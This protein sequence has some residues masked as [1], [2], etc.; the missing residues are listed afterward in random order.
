MTKVSM[1]NHSNFSDGKNTP[2]EMLLRAI[3]EGFTHYTF[4]DH[5]F[6]AFDWQWGA[7]RKEQYPDYMQ[8]V[9]ALKEKYKEQINVFVSMEAEYVPQ[10]GISTAGLEAYLPQFDYILGG[11]HMVGKDGYYFGVDEYREKFEQ[12]LEQVYGGDMRKLTEAYFSVYLS[13]IHTLKPHMSTHFDLVKKNNLDEQYFPM[14]I[15]WYRDLVADCIDAI[16][17]TDTVVEVNTGG[18]MRYGAKC[19]YSDDWVLRLFFEKHVP[20]TISSDAHNVE[21]IGSCYEIARSA[22]KRAGYTKIHVFDG[23]EF[24]PMDF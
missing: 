16:S 17:K 11:V 13:M 20:M 10:H 5:S 8:S 2:E 3:K 21:M 18:I 12:G 4:S 23:R 15:K 6:N 7:M 1:H 22:L 14:H 9:L 19:L 24:V